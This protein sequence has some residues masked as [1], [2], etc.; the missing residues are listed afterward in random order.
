[1]LVDFVAYGP[2]AETLKLVEAVEVSYYCNAL[3]MAEQLQE[4]TKADT[5]QVYNYRNGMVWFVLDW[6]GSVRMAIGQGLA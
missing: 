1:M 2:N 5:V 3:D 4:Q 6:R